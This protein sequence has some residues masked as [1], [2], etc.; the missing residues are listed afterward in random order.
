MARMAARRVSRASL[1]RL[2]TTRPAISAPPHANSRERTISSLIPS[3][4]FSSIRPGRRSASRGSSIMLLAW[5]WL[6]FSRVARS[7]RGASWVSNSNVPRGCTSTTVSPDHA[8]RTESPTSTGPT[9]ERTPPLTAMPSQAPAP[10]TA[11]MIRTL[12]VRRAACRTRGRPAAAL[13]WS[14]VP[15]ARSKIRVRS[16][17]LPAYPTGTPSATSERQNGGCDRGL[18]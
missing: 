7:R 8:G 4:R 11:M 12:A 16:M 15:F 18:A 9:G 1:I 3:R 17:R 13:A 10:A 5:S 14:N 6:M 2:N